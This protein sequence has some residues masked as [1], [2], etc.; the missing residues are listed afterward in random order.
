MFT[1]G[2]FFISLVLLHKAMCYFPVVISCDF[3]TLWHMLHMVSSYLW[4]Q[5]ERFATVRWDDLSPQE[6]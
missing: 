5:R 3:P 1:D 6:S 4:E 2:M